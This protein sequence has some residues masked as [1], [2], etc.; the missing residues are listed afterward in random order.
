MAGLRAAS[1][2]TGLGA[3]G[4]P[5]GFPACSREPRTSLRVQTGSPTSD[6]AATPPRRWHDLVNFG[7]PRP[8]PAPLAALVPAA[9]VLVLLEVGWLVGALDSVEVGRMPLYRGVLPG[10]VTLVAVR[11]CG[12]RLGFRERSSPAR[13]VIAAA[14]PVAVATALAAGLSPAEA[15]ALAASSAH[16][17]VAYRFAIPLVVAAAARAWWPDATAL[18]AGVA[19]AVPAFV[20]L[21]G[22]VA[23]MSTPLAAV[24][25]AAMAAAFA[26]AVWWGGLLG[27]AMVTHAAWNL[28]AMAAWAA[29]DST[30]VRAVQAVVG[31][32]LIV[33]L[34][35]WTAAAAVAAGRAGPY[36]VPVAVRW[37]RR[38]RAVP[39]WARSAP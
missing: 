38:V 17:E 3:G 11:A 25:F 9:V 14:V 12:F 23:Q 2:A 33:A 31:C 13:W 36:E 28:V 34:L 6:P 37:A 19:V 35:A 24:P 30:G 15:A 4:A 8:L 29:P 18:R 27:P 20:F 21:P 7:S 16:E 22:H 10:W 26:A 5:V 32:S 1:G 39:M